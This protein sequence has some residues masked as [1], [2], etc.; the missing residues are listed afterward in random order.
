MQRV[1][2]LFVSS[3]AAC[4]LAL[5][6]CSSARP[7]SG[8]PHTLAS[9]AAAYR[10]AGEDDRAKR[11]LCIAAIDAGIIAPGVPL[12]VIDQLCGSDFDRSV[13][14]RENGLEYGIV[15]FHPPFPNYTTDE[16]QV[17]AG[18]Y[19][20]WYMI[21]EYSGTWIENYSLSNKHK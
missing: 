18:G 7:V 5:S 8:P 21:V 4:A 12:A 11:D 13:G 16:G 2:G 14:R 17:A 10:T 20:G 15:H 6:G 9:V 19:V 3:S 1:P